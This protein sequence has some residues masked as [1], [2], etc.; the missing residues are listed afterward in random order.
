METQSDNTQPTEAEI[1]HPTE[2]VKVT[3][4]GK[5]IPLKRLTMRDT[6]DLMQDMM[7]MVSVAGENSPGFD[8]KNF[9]SD[10]QALV[11]LSQMEVMFKVPA[12]LAGLT[13]DEFLDGD[14]E[15]AS[16]LFK[17]V[18]STADVKKVF[19]NLS[20]GWNQMNLQEPTQTEAIQT[21]SS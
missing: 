19:A 9:D 13:E 1:I 16:V 11:M 15:E 7:K 3:W 14:P 10:K 8:I 17:T 12:R 4:K 20:E 2:T 21:H 5:S 18:M 6:I